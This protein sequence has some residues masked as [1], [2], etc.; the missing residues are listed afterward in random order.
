MKT[1]LGIEINDK[2]EYEKAYKIEADVIVTAVV[3]GF[4][5]TRYHLNQPCI[6]GAE[7]P[8]Q[9]DKV[10]GAS[11]DVSKQ[12]MGD[13]EKE[14][15]SKE[16]EEYQR[17]QGV[18][19]TVSYVLREHNKEFGDYLVSLP[20][21]QWEEGALITGR[22]GGHMM[23]H[24][25]RH[26]KMLG[27]TSKRLTKLIAEKPAEY[28]VYA[29]KGAY[30]GMIDDPVNDHIMIRPTKRVIDYDG[31]RWHPGQDYLNWGLIRPEGQEEIK[32]SKD[33]NKGMGPLPEK[34]NTPDR[35]GYIHGMCSAVAKCV[36]AGAWCTPYE[37]ATGKVTTKMAS[38]FA[39][40]TYMYAAGFPP[41]L[42]H[43]GRGESWVPPAPRLVS[44]EQVDPEMP[45]HYEDSI[46]QS[47]ATRW[48]WEIYHYLRLG[49]S[50]LYRSNEVELYKDKQSEFAS[51][52]IKKTVGEYVNTGHSD[53]VIALN[54]ALERLEQRHNKQ[55]ADIG[56][57]GGNLFLD[58]LTVH[59]S[60]WKRIERTLQPA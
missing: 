48:H 58:A 50:Y 9:K 12:K 4:V 31:N 19:K 56:S 23:Q 27:E 33:T 1:I 43:L 51:Y 14:P 30:T 49:S 59:D 13:K 22:A 21:P 35:I 32:L 6:F 46:T 44:G 39:C 52:L 26:R 37:L 10:E 17:F 24:D 3:L 7:G 36:S 40:T 45:V 47:L 54:A 8:S 38:C 34:V 5:G 28:E 16:Q 53:S 25:E 42:S 2:E 41:S 11:A 20:S 18:M 60:D 55:R 15:L 57:I 29:G